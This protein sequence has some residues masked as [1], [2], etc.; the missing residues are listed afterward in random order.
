MKFRDIFLAVLIIAAF[1]A[2]FLVSFLIVGFNNIKNNWVQYRCNPMILPFASFFGHD[3]ADNFAQCVAQLQST[4]M[5]Y[6]QAPL[7]AATGGLQQNLGALSGQFSGIRDLQSKLRPA[8]GGQF[9]N[10]FGVFNNVL[11]E[12]Q[13]FIIGFRDLIMKLIGVM[14]V[15]M[16]MMQG[17][18]LMGQSIIKGPIIGSLKTIQKYS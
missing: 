16:H 10:V 12:M 8:I 17:Q 11:I 1:Y 13:K 18:Q 3:T 7:A 15:L 14:S 4:T 6:H 9:T 2:C 5:P